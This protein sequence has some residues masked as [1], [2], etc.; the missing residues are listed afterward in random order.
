[1]VSTMKYDL[2]E[3]KNK[4]NI[5]YIIKNLKKNQQVIEF[6]KFIIKYFIYTN[7]SAILISN[8]IDRHII[9]N[10]TNSTDVR[11]N[12]IYQQKDNIEDLDI[13]F[14]LSLCVHIDNYVNTANTTDHLKNN[15]LLCLERLKQIAL[16]DIILDDIFDETLELKQDLINSLTNIK[17]NLSNV[18][19]IKNCGLQSLN[20]ILH[21]RHNTPLDEANIKNFVNK[22]KQIFN[23]LK[24]QALVQD[25][26][27]FKELFVL[28]I[29]FYNKII[30]NTNKNIL[31]NLFQRTFD[32]DLI[33][34]QISGKFD[35]NI[36]FYNIKN[37]F[38]SLN[39]LQNVDLKQD[40][41]LYPILSCFKN[42][43]T[44]ATKILIAPYELSRVIMD[45]SDSLIN[46]DSL[47]HI[48]NNLYF[49]AK[50]NL[51]LI[52]SNI[53]NKF[54]FLQRLYD[55][56]LK[57]YAKLGLNFNSLRGF[58]KSTLRRNMSFVYFLDEKNK[59]TIYDTEQL[60]FTIQQQNIVSTNFE[61]LIRR[62]NSK[63]SEQHLNLEYIQFI[64][65]SLFLNQCIESNYRSNVITSKLNSIYLQYKVNSKIFTVLIPNDLINVFLQILIKANI[66]NQAIY[67][68]FYYKDI[69]FKENELESYLLTKIKD[70]LDN[71]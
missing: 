65:K 48:I 38:M 33:N 40:A 47:D 44:K 31:S 42:R 10:L 24:L 25:N 59:V 67:N 35:N 17:N 18:L 57:Y 51:L 26:N 54:E 55:N 46:Y 4:K 21:K 62:I 28:L 3:K 66:V 23:N 37:A 69:L 71:I 53:D 32:I 11:F 43:T 19:Y 8:N 16:D 30:S 45:I 36:N 29:D 50:Q 7:I 70:S 49:L 64:S 1:M 60:F 58:I 56:Q 61:F 13:N 12:Q 6:E 14:L 39:F 41:F 5:V 15:L 2:L 63:L 52:D 27:D 9:I 20:D 68:S 34:H 22:F